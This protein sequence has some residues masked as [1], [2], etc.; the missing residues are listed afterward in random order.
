MHVMKCSR[1]VKFC[2]V[3]EILKWTQIR[4]VW[5]PS[6]Y[7]SQTTKNTL[8]TKLLYAKVFHNTIRKNFVIRM[9]AITP[10]RS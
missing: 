10:A 5:G 3:L 9:A 6:I 7:E 8:L 2:I 1:I 4:G